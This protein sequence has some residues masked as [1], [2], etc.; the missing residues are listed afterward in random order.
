MSN[1][2]MSGPLRATADA[3]PGR[4]ALRFL[5]VLSGLMSLGSLS[6]DMYLPALPT[7]AGVFHVGIGAVQFTL[8]TF[9]VGFCVGQLIWG[10]LGDRYGRR[11]MAAIGLAIFVI[12]SSGCAL[13]GSVGG[14]TAWRAIQAFGAAAG[15][16]LARA[17][18]R[19]LYARNDAARML[20][21]LIL[22]MGI[23]PLLGPIL[24]GQVLVFWNWQG[25][26]GV[27]AL[28]GV[29]GLLGLATIHET[30]RPENRATLRPVEL[31]VSYG[32]MITQPRLL[33]YALSGATFY[34]AA[35]A[36]LAG[37]PHA[38]IEIYHVSPQLYGALFGLNIV[39]MMASNAINSRFVMRVGLNRML[40]LGILVMAL[41]GVAITVTGFTGFGG[42]AGLVAPA[43]IIVSMN[44]A[45]VA[46][47]VAGA[48]SAYP[49][50]AG[51]AS[52]VVGAV[53]FG[54]GVLTTAMTGWFADGTAFTYAWIIGLT[55][56]GGLA[57]TIC[58]VRGPQQD[59]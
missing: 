28:L 41:G 3:P 50:K 39:G 19:D 58:L 9:L 56:V 23:A 44:G 40:R 5:F 31:L 37:S 21:V 20:S 43:F 54:I 36:Y 1:A 35:Y 32:Q 6:T 29:G 52:A 13:S 22:G 12:G 46:N 25:I 33:G 7:L 59:S 17:M 42:L 30:L 11:N 51:A 48:L 38:Y 27:Q 2:L 49:R 53:Q 57:A 26:F 47:S 45:V 55:T 24:G 10:P 14:M 34:G 18:V 4:P 15:P 16:V 8:T